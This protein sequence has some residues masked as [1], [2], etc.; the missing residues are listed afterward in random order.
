MHIA[1]NTAANAYRREVDAQTNDVEHVD[2]LLLTE[3]RR[4]LVEWLGVP[5]GSPK[6]VQEALR[7]QEL[8][9]R[10]TVLFEDEATAERAK[11]D[12]DPMEQVTR[13]AQDYETAW[14]R[15][16]AMVLEDELYPQVTPERAALVEQVDEMLGQIVADEDRRLREARDPDRWKTHRV[17]RTELA[18]RIVRR[19]WPDA[20]EDFFPLAVSLIAQR[21]EDN[22]PT[23][24]REG[25]PLAP[26]LAE[27]IEAQIK[28]TPAN[29]LPF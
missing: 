24:H 29:Q 9:D 10:Q 16:R 20:R 14:M 6:I 19:V 11:M 28:V 15:A 3:T 4:I 27:M 5:M 17:Q 1:D 8:I 21:L 22:E 2:A 7:L 25:H 18:Y 26:E 23:P 12:L 13:A